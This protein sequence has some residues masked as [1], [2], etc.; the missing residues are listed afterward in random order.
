MPDWRNRRPSRRERELAWH[1]HLDVATRAPFLGV[2]PGRELDS[3]VGEAL[4]DSRAVHAA[5]QKLAVGITPDRPLVPAVLDA[6]VATSGLL[7]LRSSWI[8]Y[9][10]E[11]F[12]LDP[13]VEDATSEMSRQYVA[14]DVVRAWSRFTEGK[15][16][17]DEATEA[18][19]QLQPMLAKFCG[20]DPRSAISVA[21][22]GLGRSGLRLVTDIRASR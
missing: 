19:R 17:Y 5:L 6:A 15:A 18:V 12:A 1:A 13:A 10:N 11:R 21:P 8:D 20:L 7:A 22:D 4:Y 9:C 16:A 2:M 3:L 14:G